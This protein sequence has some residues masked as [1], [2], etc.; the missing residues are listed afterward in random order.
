MVT[1]AYQSNRY[2]LYALFQTVQQVD[3]VTVWL[4]C[5]LIFV[6]FPHFNP[7]IEEILELKNRE[8]L[9]IYSYIWYRKIFLLVALAFPVDCKHGRRWALHGTSVKSKDSSSKMHTTLKKIINQDKYWRFWRS[10]RKVR[11]KTTNALGKFFWMQY[12][13]KNILS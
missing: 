2:L 5:S 1:F 6:Y 4:W 11:L 10:S 13:A 12:F 7:T 9:T 3:T 8:K